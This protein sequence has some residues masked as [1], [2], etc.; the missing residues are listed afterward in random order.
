M[1]FLLDS[2]VLIALTVFAHVH[3]Q[4]VDAWMK[5]AHPTCAVCPITEGALVRCFVKLGGHSGAATAKDTLRRLMARGDFLFWPDD[6]S[7]VD[8]PTRGLTGHKQVTD[9]YLVSLA[10]ARGAKLAT[11]DAGIASLFPDTCDLI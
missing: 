5:S 7:Y 10:R 1:I 2:N 3:E 11:M 9:F 8:L 4:R 6:L